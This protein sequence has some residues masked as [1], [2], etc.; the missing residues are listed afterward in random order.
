M[1]GGF[2]VLGVEDRKDGRLR[3]SL[4]AGPFSCWNDADRAGPMV[5]AHI[6]DNMA[7]PYHVAYNICEFYSPELVPGV[8]NKELWVAPNPI[9]RG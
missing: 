7:L 4:V 5:I 3:V 9:M 2:Y 1:I 6:R 8:L